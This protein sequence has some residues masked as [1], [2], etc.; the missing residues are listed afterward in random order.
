MVKQ[1]C[2][3]L[4]VD[5]NEDILFMIKAMLEMKGYGVI[6]KDSPSNIEQ[7]IVEAQ[8]DIILMDMLLSGADGREVCQ[9]IKAGNKISHIPIIMISALPDAEISCFSAGANYFLSKPFDMYDLFSTVEKA[10]VYN[11]KIN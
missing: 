11:T 1:Q 7:A 3:I 5:D 2:K 10:A 8:P 4:V 9:K 6:A